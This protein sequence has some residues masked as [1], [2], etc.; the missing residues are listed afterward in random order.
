[1]HAC[2]LGN[3]FHLKSVA[4]RTKSTGTSVS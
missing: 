2:F 1:M 4:L 3:K